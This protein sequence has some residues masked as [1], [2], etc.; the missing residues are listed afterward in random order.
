MSKLVFLFVMDIAIALGIEIPCNLIL[1][2]IV[3]LSISLACDYV[4]L[5]VIFH[6]HKQCSVSFHVV[7]L[8]IIFSHAIMKLIL[9]ARWI[10]QLDGSS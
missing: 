5:I 4:L 7:E 3:F 6:Q 1:R 10:S 2:P 9:L 8:D